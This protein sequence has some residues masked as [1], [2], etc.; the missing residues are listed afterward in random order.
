MF[1]SIF[2][3]LSKA[4]QIIGSF[5]SAETKHCA[6]ISNTTAHS[7]LV[8]ARYLPAYC[9]N[10]RLLAETA[11]TSQVAGLISSNTTTSEYANEARVTFQS[12]DTNG[13]GILDMSELSAGL[14]DFGLT[15]TEIESLF[16]GLDRNN[17]K[18]VSALLAIH[19]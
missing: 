4:V 19:C 6:R 2:K 7:C 14:C 3:N 15:D 16:F 12:I 18:Q 1:P 11:N 5:Q 9:F 17:D 13:D 8:L 10:A